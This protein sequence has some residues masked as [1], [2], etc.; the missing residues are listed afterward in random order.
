ML[1]TQ[2]LHF[3]TTAMATRKLVGSFNL[4]LQFLVHKQLQTMIQNSSNINELSFRGQHKCGCLPGGI[5]PFVNLKCV[6]GNPN[7]G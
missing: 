5:A 1:F 3:I 4:E 7:T 6:V 2:R